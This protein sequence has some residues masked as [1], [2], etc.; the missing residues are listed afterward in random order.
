[1]GESVYEKLVDFQRM[2]LKKIKIC[3]RS[4]RWWDSELSLQVKVVRRARRN[5]QRVGHRNVLRSELTRMKQ[6][7]REKKHKCLR[8][9]CEDSGLQSPWEVVRWAWDPWR[10][11]E[12]M[13]CLRGANRLWMDGDEEKVRFLVS[14][15]VGTPSADTR[16]LAQ[17]WDRCPMTRDELE[18][19]VRMALGGTKNGS[20]PGLDGISYRLIKAVRDTRLG[21]EVIEE[22]VD[23]LWRGII[24]DAWRQTRVVFIPKPSRDLTLAR[25]WRPLNLIN[26]IGK[27]GEKVV[28]DRILDY[29][30]GLFHRLQYGSV[31][32]R[33]AIDVLYKSV[34]KERNCMESG[35]SVGWG[36][37]DVKGGFQNVVGEEVL[38]QLQGVEGTKGLCG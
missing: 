1:M 3:G 25:N 28:A 20:A 30:N 8:A 36:F 35:G 16:V 4:K 15:V 9:F 2:H 24:P 38:R 32:G 19:S 21:E 29:G 31:R 34:V 13:G 12:R 5:W 37:W 26:C 6:K 27:L 17:G 23:S 18:C 10:E 7:M 22:V 33:S 14:E 11:K